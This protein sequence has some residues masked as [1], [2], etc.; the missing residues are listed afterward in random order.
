MLNL[1]SVGSVID[2]K[3]K[4]VYPKYKNGII[5]FDNGVHVVECSNEWYSSLNRL[6]SKNLR[7]LPIK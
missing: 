7:E 5:D 3:T 1:K 6:D 4:I 2:T